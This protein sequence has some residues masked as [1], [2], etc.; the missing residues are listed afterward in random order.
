MEQGAVDDGVEPPVIAPER[1]DV[2]LNERRVGQ[3]ALVGSFGGGCDGGRREVDSD[4]RVPLVGECKRQLGIPA[5]GVEHVAADLPALD[6]RG[7]FWLRLADVPRRRT[8]E[9]AVLSVGVVP[10]HNVV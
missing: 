1:R 6:Q 9:G 5:P 4:D 2:V 7:E 8:L 3:T 10:L